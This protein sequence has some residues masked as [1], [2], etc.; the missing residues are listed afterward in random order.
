MKE[1]DCT[2]MDE[3]ANLVC[4]IRENLLFEFD[5]AGIAPISEQHYLA[6]LAS[7]ELAVRSFKIAH[8]HQLKGE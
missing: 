5:D 8:L 6:G 7:L 3:I 2:Q 1:Y 4:E